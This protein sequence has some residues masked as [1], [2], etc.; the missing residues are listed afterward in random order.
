MD[1]IA[2]EVAQ[3]ILVLFKHDNGHAGARQ[4]KSKHHSSGTTAGNAARGFD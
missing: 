4:Q 2:S 3:K 1:G